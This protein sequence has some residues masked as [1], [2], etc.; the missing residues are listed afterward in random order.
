MPNGGYKTAGLI[1]NVQEIK[2]REE[3]LVAAR[4]LAEKAELKQSFLANMS[5]EIRTPLNS[6][7]GFS[8]ILAIEEDLSPEE[9]QEYIDTIN[10]NSDLLL[11][12]VNDIL[13]LSRMES[14]Y[15]S[16]NCEKCMVNELIDDVYMTHQV[17]IMPRLNFLKE[18]DDMQLEIDVDKDR[19]TQVLTNFLNNASKFTESGYVKIG[20]HYLLEEQ[21]VAVYVEDTGRGIPQEEQKII[22]SRFYKQNEF[23]QGAGLGLSICRVIIDK[24]GGTIELSSEPGKGSRFTVIL[25]CRH[26]L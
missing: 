14:G 5:H 24:L 9:R 7:V 11:K 17:L 16:F 10:N 15:M 23:S 3:E 13:E 25:P 12:L 21:K 6:I 20:Y 2:D 18:I 19:L 26:I 22:F 8:N 4:L 1:L